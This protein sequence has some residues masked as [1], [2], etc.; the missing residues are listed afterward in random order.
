MGQSL[1]DRFRVEGLNAHWF[2]CA[3]EAHQGFTEAAYDL[4]VCDIRLPDGQGDRLYEDLVQTRI[5]LPPFIFIT[6][7]GQ[8]ERA[9]ELMRLGAVDYLTKP[10]AMDQLLARIREHLPAAGTQSRSD[11]RP[12][13]GI[14]PAMRAIEALLQRL[15]DRPLPVLITGE[16]GVGKEVVA[17][18]LHELGRG[19]PFVAVNCAALVE[20]LTESELFGHERGAFT[21]A[22]RRHRGVFERARGGTL[23]FDE[24]GDLPIALQAKLLRVLQEA[25][26]TRVG[27]EESLA[28]KARLVFATHRDLQARIAQG[29]FRED[30][31]YRIN[32]MQVPV[33]PLRER[34]QDIPWLARSFLQEFGREY[35]LGPLRLHPFAE[36]ALVQRPWPGN[37]RELHHCL[38]RACLFVERGTVLLQDLDPRLAT[39]LE[40]DAP[41]TLRE[42]VADS[43]RQYIRHALKSEDG[44]ICAAARRL[45]ISRKVMWEKMKRLGVKA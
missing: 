33:P 44:R 42:Y 21:G 34:C 13:L 37:V 31:Y 35:G 15:A 41:P 7:Y 10:F 8:I 11:G 43:E 26:Y 45:G 23:F 2:T 39:P 17:R 32:V 18:R 5:P 12:R 22:V 38:Q 3:R 36:R 25:R 4:A 29:L 20:G 27:G 16:T 28:V 30:L 9:V 14:S 24:V 1:M 19:G 40:P 6:A